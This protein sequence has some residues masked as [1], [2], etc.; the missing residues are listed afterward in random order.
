MEHDQ[1]HFQPVG[2]RIGG[3][4]RKRNPAFNKD[5][6]GKGKEAASQDDDEE[7]EEEEWEEC[8]AQDPEAE[9]IYEAWA[10]SL[11]VEDSPFE[12]WADLDERRPS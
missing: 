1:E 2:T 4:G 5:Q 8:E 6:A 3:F 7:E 11:E 9:V 10:V 12:G